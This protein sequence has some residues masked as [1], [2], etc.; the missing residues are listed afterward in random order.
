[1]TVAPFVGAWIE[2]H[3]A[4]YKMIPGTV[5]PFVGAW[6]ETLSGAGSGSWELSSLLS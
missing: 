6:I 2:T 4:R 3:N 5:A 1:M